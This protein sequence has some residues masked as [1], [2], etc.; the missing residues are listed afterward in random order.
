[1]NTSDTII[2]GIYFKD[3]I[4]FRETGLRETILISYSTEHI[5]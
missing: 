2:T 1:M 3:T 4:N 5:L